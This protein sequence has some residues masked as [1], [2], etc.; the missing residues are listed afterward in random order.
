MKSSNYLN[1]LVLILSFGLFS[2]GEKSNDPI[3]TPDPTPVPVV[4]TPEVQKPADNDYLSRLE[5]P[6]TK[7]GN[8]FIYH[9]TKEGNDSVM[10]YC[11]EFDPK[12]I[13]VVGSHSVLMLCQYSRIQNVLK[14]TLCR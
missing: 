1:A 14:Q 11:L 7:D 2:C 13:I 5:V 10:T 12:N 6:K 3:V 4:P 8:I 9:C